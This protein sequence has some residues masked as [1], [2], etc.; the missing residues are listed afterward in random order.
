MAV[1]N[2]AVVHRANGMHTSG[3]L[4]AVDPFFSDLFV[5]LTLQQ[6]LLVATGVVFGCTRKDWRKA[7]VATLAI[8]TMSISRDKVI[9]SF[10]QSSTPTMNTLAD[11]ESGF[12]EQAALLAH[13]T[14]SSLTGAT[15]MWQEWRKPGSL[16]RN[17]HRHYWGQKLSSSRTGI[18]QI[19][20]ASRSDCICFVRQR[21]AGGRLGHLI[22]HS[23]HSASNS[24]GM[25]CP[26]R[27]NL[28]LSRRISGSR[29]L[30]IE[31]RL[32][33]VD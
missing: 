16:L 10:S 22:L 13:L 14:S 9:G 33:E 18:D 21:V 24:R 30:Q 8:M 28:A 32:L 29:D 12:V 25:S 1:V 17:D 31:D 26:A 15:G 7:Y 3:A 5:V 27:L 2:V 4:R 11:H 6:I 23:G 20:F 19:R